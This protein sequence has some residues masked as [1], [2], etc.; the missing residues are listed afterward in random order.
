VV[1]LRRD[2]LVV[3][4]G[5]ELGWLRGYKLPH[6]RW[7]AAGGEC[8]REG[9]V[10]TGLVSVDQGLKEHWTGPNSF[11]VTVVGARNLPREAPH[12]KP[13]SFCSLII[14]GVRKDTQ[15]GRR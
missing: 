7:E 14:D 8:C 6:D 13:D 5:E 9:W 1:P 2:D 10:E 4:L 3:L 15:V 12:Q 11:T